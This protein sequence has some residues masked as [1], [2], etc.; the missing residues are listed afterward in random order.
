MRPKRQAVTLLELLIAIVLLSV[1]TIGLSSIDLFSRYHVLTADRRVRL[2]NEVSLALEHMTKHISQAIGSTLRLDRNT[3][4]A[5][6][7]YQNTQGF[8]IRIDSNPV[9]GRP[10]QTDTWIAY[11]HEPINGPQPDSGIFY[12]S[13]AGATEPPGGNPEII[14]HKVVT[15]NTGFT[16][17]LTD[18]YL[19]IG[20]VCRWDPTQPRSADN[21]EI[22]L[23]TTIKMPS[24]S[25]H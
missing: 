11:C 18:N 12:Y 13:N 17:I 19:T 21:P 25:T 15:D 8:R 5:V 24:V 3:D 22:S 6:V 10:D 9:N 16:Y 14:T 7:F 20:I 23:N 2:Q 1:I 4:P